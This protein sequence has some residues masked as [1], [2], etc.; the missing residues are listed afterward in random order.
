[1]EVSV[2]LNDEFD[3][4]EPPT[5]DLKKPREAK[6]HLTL[7]AG[8]RPAAKTDLDAPDEAYTNALSDPDEPS[9]A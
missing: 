9:A 2:S 8:R 3:P 6:Q 7:V 4:G 1:M 5:R